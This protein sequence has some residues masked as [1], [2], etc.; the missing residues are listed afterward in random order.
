MIESR[1]KRHTH[2]VTKTY[3][4]K[5]M[6]DERVTRRRECCVYGERRENE[7]GPAGKSGKSVTAAEVTY[8]I[9][10][11]VDGGEGRR[12]RHPRARA[13][14]RSS[15][16]LSPPRNGG[17]GG[18]VRERTAT[19]AALVD[20]CC[21]C[22]RPSPSLPPRAHRFVTTPM[23]VRRCARV[24]FSAG[25]HCACASF[26]YNPPPYLRNTR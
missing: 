2:T 18:V 8:T 4:H 24:C 16:G 15:S 7:L 9:R 10:R 6:D 12:S 3:R 20:R 1:R 25:Y 17:G 13:R 11:T 22:R 19:G 23:T 14:T 26:Y 5:K 21:C